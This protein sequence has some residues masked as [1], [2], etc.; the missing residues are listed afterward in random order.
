M[1]E[2][3]FFLKDICD[4][5]GQIEIYTQPGKAEFIESRLIQ[6][7]VIRNFELIGEGV[8]RLS[9]S[10]RQTYPAIPWRKIAGFRDVLIHDYL[11]IDLD[12]V[13]D[14]IDRNLPELKHNILQIIQKLEDES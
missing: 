5:I 9:S 4:R 11:Q 6:D 8:K 10:L 1:N 14:V 2:D 7:A 13:W 3:L 12:E